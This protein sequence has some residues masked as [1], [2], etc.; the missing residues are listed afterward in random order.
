MMKG[1]RKIKDKNKAYQ[2]IRILGDQETQI[3][4]KSF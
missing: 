1:I 3:P 2:N 4:E